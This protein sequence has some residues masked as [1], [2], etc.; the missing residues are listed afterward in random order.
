[1]RF[2]RSR[3][4]CSP[5][6]RSPRLRRRPRGAAEDTGRRRATSPDASRWTARAPSAPTRPRRPSGSSSRTP[7]S[8]SRSASRAPAAASSASAPARRT[9]RTRPARSRTTR[10]RL[11]EE[12][13]IEYVEFQVANDALTVVV[14]PENDWADCLTVAQ[15]KKIWD[16]GSKVKTWSDVRAGSRRA[17]EALRRR[18]RLRHV[19]LLHGRDQRRGGRA[20]PT[21]RRPR[22]TTCSSRASPATRGR[23]ATSA[24]RTSSRTRTRSRRSRSTAATAASHRASRPRR[25]GR[26][27]RSRGRSSS[28][29]RRR[30]RATGGRGVPRVH[31]R[32]R[33]GDRRGAAQFVPLTDEQLEK[34]KSDLE[35]ATA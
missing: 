29:S 25:A 23:S 33:A 12:N 9:S 26:T 5:G 15:L 35:A 28:T 19:R 18:H 24:S 7:T 21:T 31:P 14:N 17:A 1:M 8:R 16:P 11:C 27:S 3:R 30:R 2:A 6:A 34:A 10:R 22:T 4:P 20:A 32:Q 13:G